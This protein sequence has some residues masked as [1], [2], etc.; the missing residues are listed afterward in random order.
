VTAGV[1]ARN[2]MAAANA[3]GTATISQVLD[4]HVRLEVECL[5]RIYLNAYVP[6][7]QVGGQVVRF[8][9]EHLGNPI[10]SPALFG[11][12]GERFR[13]AVARFATANAIPVV[14]FDRDQRKAEVMRPL[15]EAAAH[16]GVSR[17]VAVG[18][19]QEYQRVFCGYDRGRGDGQP[20]PPR[21]AFEKADRRVS[22]FYFSVWDAEFG[23]G[24]IKLC[25]YFPYPAKVWVNG[26]EWA[27]R[28][29]RTAGIGFT[30]L[31]SG[32]ASC[33]DP[34]ALQAICDRL[35]PGQIQAFF[36]RWLKVIPTPRGGRH[37]QL[38][39]QALPHQ[40]V[41]QRRP[42]AAGVD[43][44]AVHALDLRVDA[45]GDDALWMDADELAAEVRLQWGLVRQRLGVAA[46][47]NA[48]DPPWLQGDEV[49]DDEGDSPIGLDVA[50]LAAGAQFV[51]ADVDRSGVGVVAEADGVVLRGAVAGDGC[52]APKS[53]GG[54]VGTFGKAAD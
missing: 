19:A 36:D 5:D 23:P 30:E 6:V 18:V 9:T 33:D 35:G 48:A 2:A 49:V 38:L 44:S 8:L 1:R 21:Y 41:P 26:H 10:P 54:Q 28:Q 39:L 20:G 29:A 37:R 43:V 3:A 47:L 15:L 34:H 16:D 46:D 24:F 51:P 12:I 52:Q 4:G 22:C 7:L 11:P 31:A 17:V 50:V 53:L 27:K 13:H 40:A 25:S 32:F 14:R 42:R 45:P